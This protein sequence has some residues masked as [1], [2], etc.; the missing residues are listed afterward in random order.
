MST[1]DKVDGLNNLELQAAE[2]ISYI[3]NYFHDSNYYTK[4]LADSTFFKSPAHSG[5]RSD[6]GHGSGIDAASVDGF[7]KSALQSLSL[8]AGIIAVWAKAVS[9]IPIARWLHCNGQNSTPDFR[10]R[11]LV[12]AGGGYSAG[13][14]GGGL[15]VVPYCP[16]FDSDLV[17]LTTNQ[18]PKHR[19][20]YTDYITT[21]YGGS[22]SYD[23]SN[24]GNYGGVSDITR[25]LNGTPN[26]AVT[27]H[28]H[29]SNTLTFT[30][31]YDEDDVLH[32]GSLQ[33]MPKSKAL[34]YILRR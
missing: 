7:S 31:Y 32:S 3:D 29:F 15:D 14:T 34:A 8:P 21:G 20:T 19:H 22:G 25:G 12:G 33:I 10:G 13:V 18:I 24:L 2:G 17:A 16:T 5:G 27:A 11:L 4:T 23:Y 30:G 28:G 6:T 1:Q 9:S 26:K